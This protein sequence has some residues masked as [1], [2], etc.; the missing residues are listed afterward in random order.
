MTNPLLQAYEF[1]PFSR[2]RPEHVE[3]A[4][5]RILHDNRQQVA[6]LLQRGGPYTWD[7]LI[8]PLE[9]LDDRLDKAWSPVRHLNAVVNSEALRQAYNACLPKLSDYATDLG[10]NEALYQAHQTIAA[11]EEF[12]RLDPAQRKIIQDAL[13]DFRLA[14]VALPPERKAR[15]K[16]IEQRLSK[17]ASRFEENVLD[18]TNAWT[19]HVTDEARLQ[20]LPETA[21][22]V[23]RQAAAARGLDGWLLT[24]EFPCYAAVMTFADD[25]GL[26]R[27]LYEA[28]VTR[29]SD[30]GPHAGRWDNTEVMEE[31]LQLRHEKARLLGYANF[32]ELSLATKMAET[33]QQVLDFL[34]ELAARS[35]P[36]AERD[37][38][39]LRRFARDH[40]GIDE[41]QAW[42]LMY[43]S[44]KLR[45]HKFRLSQEEV[46]QY[47]P[48]TRV[49]P[50][51]FRVVERLY[52]LDIQAL[53]GIDVWHPDVRCYEIRD[54][55]GEV[56]GRFYLDLYARPKKRGGAWMDECVARR[57]L[58]GQVQ[59]PIAF[60]T[61][62]FTPPAGNDPALLTHDEVLTLFHEF[63][64]GLHHLLTQVDYSGVS[65]IRGVEWDAV[66]LPSQFMENFCWQRETLDLIS[67]H[68]RSGEPLPE[69]LFQKMLAAKNFQA[70]MMMVR[71][72]EFALFDFRI[73]LE[74][75]PARGGR[76]YEILEEVRDQV[77]VFRPPAFNRFAHSFSHIFGGGYAAGY[78]SYK[79]AE[80]LSADA[81]SRFE[82]EGIFDP[83]I[84]RAFLQHILEVG[85]SRPALESFK[86]FR[87]REPKID[88]LLRHSG[89]S[90]EE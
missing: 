66:E 84:G 67:G 52:G 8:R 56:R 80:V 70:G 72:L 11:S 57:R 54:A 24:L 63:G 77:A 88:A 9:D 16:A 86:A 14:G 20:G 1:P 22:T 2:I 50:G 30:Q 3:P 32:A 15:F 44:E 55:R 17:L 49:V 79:W 25:R 7:N 85:G 28:Y 60:L 78:Y 37:L 69:A 34:H 5:T 83:A 40:H 23:A 51:L 73:H 12:Q 46:K 71:Q 75:D 31:I 6:R 19:K 76:I 21:K 36:V 42:D 10:Q 27:E 39:E 35:K 89:I 58:Q 18:A 4:I 62:N 47:F 13:R 26:R 65:G 74:Y 87:G 45:Q 59:V 53:E 41:L 61:C 64:H 33:P 82:E 90:T 43:Y 38:T 29:A 81:F 68:Y 48:A